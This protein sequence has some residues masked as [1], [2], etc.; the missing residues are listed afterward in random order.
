M[1]AQDS[2]ATEARPGPG[3]G[4]LALLRNAWRQLTSMRTALML[5]F[6][7]A[8]AAVPGSLLPQRAVALEKVGDYLRAHPDS[9]PWLDRFYLFDVYSS[10]WFAAIYLLLFTSLIGCILPRLRAQAESL[11]RPPPAAPSR[12]DRLP[13]SL[14]HPSSRS[15]QD[16]AAVLRRA[17]FRVAVRDGAVSA[18]KGYLR[19][20]GNLLFH[21]A[22]I[23][24]LVGVAL[25]SWYGWHGN[26]IVVEGPE[27]EFCNTLQQY[28][29]YALGPRLGAEDL[30]PF[31]VRLDTFHAGYLDNGQP[32]S[33]SADVTYTENGPE[34]KKSLAVNSP[35]RLHGANVYLLGHGYAPVLEY[36]DRFGRRQTTTAVFLPQDGMLTSSGVA[37][38]PDANLDPATG[39]RDPSQ[40]LGFQGV[41]LPTVP[42]NVS[43]GSS[44][45][46]EERN[47]ALMLVAYQGNLGV[48]NGIPRSVYSLDKAQID[49]GRLKKLGEPHMLLKGGEPW[50]LA[51][52]SSIRFL[53]TK[54]WATVSVRNDPGEPVMLA[55]AVL[56]LLGLLPSLALRRR[57]VFVRVTD[58]VLTAGA[59]AKNE[60]PG[61]AEELELLMEEK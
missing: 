20:T 48:D 40:Q 61:L 13:V 8:V 57:R 6:L 2:R 52:G 9:G 42:D 22:L 26:R 45:H 25:G 32:L 49:A 30:P 55:G 41:Y 28:D 47:P 10:P 15:V 29:E 11:L 58:G 60:Y 23:V 59:L 38:F 27:G 14:S 3:A 34:K 37:I 1:A 19:E 21:T 5:L 44:K 16:V 46:P 36:T 43:D 4:P 7:L 31:C 39:R 50:K 17:R 24:L 56:L 33:F 53:G 54:K 18:E 35:L 51:D 12:L